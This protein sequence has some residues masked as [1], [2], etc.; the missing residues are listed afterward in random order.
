MTSCEE[1][2]RSEEMEGNME[3]VALV[4]RVPSS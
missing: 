2:V 3:D 1:L 4:N